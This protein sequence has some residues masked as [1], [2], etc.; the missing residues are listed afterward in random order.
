MFC[1]APPAKHHCPREIHLVVDATYFGKRTED[2][3]WC[4]V[5]AR[6]PYESENLWW[7]FV[8]TETT[9]VYL[10]M[11]KDLESLGYTIL[12]V[13]GDGFGGIKTAFQG[14]PYQMCQVH[15]ERLVTKGT[16]KYPKL[17]EG[18]ILLALV[19]TLPY[20]DSHTFHVRL[21]QYTDM[22]HGF[23]NEKTI[24]P[25]SGEWSWT[26]ES[27][28]LAVSALRRWKNYLFTYK[29]NKTIPKTTNSLE[30][31]F[32][33]IKRLTC[34]HC[35]LSKTHKIKVLNTI[36]LAGTTAPSDELL[37]NIL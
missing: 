28:R 29:H 37:K 3:I 35:G 25:L 21:K 7:S 23:L 32:R 1:Y 8:H 19:R 16:T 27:L 14:I 20:T 34:V 24:H 13:T 2:T 9:G 17:Q 33:H 30:G 26:H 5:V 12:S 31:H 36:L 15:M 18:Q 6:D 10:A 11:R 22:Y 4:L